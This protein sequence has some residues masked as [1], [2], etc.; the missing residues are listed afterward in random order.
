MI[1]NLNGK[2]FEVSEIKSVSNCSCN[3]DIKLDYE[4]GNEKVSYRSVIFDINSDECWAGHEVIINGLE[5]GFEAQNGTY[6]SC[7]DSKIKA[8]YDEYYS[9]L[10]DFL[11][12][13]LGDEYGT[14]A[15]EEYDGSGDKHAEKKMNALKEYVAENKLKYYIDKERGFSNEWTIYLVPE[16]WD[17]SDVMD[18]LEEIS[19]ESAI[20]YLTIEY[21]Y[22]CTSLK[23]ITWI[24][25][26]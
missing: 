22:D 23:Q 9:T 12:D 14:W 15:C 3:V 6:W 17:I 8:L 20:E 1:K 4:D 11:Q 26:E 25:G 2:Q 24:E 19:E 21:E 7:E 13:L 18:D 10:Y 16:E 5:I